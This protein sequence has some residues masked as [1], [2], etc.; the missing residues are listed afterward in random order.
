MKVLFYCGMP[1]SLAHGGAQIQ[2]EQTILALQKIGVDV[3]PAQWWE[4]LPKVDIYHHF[5]RPPAEVVRLAHAKGVRVVLQELLTEQGSRSRNR[6]RVQKWVRHAVQAT[7]PAMVSQVFGWESYR[8]AD[9]LIAN[10]TWEAHLM[11]YLFGAPADRVHVIANGIEE[12]FLNSAPCERGPWLICTATITHRKRVLEL[13]QAATL[14]RV[15]VWIIGKPYAENDS[16]GA[17]FLRLAKAKPEF[18]RYEGPISDR[19]RLAGIY[20]QA[21]G[22][23]LL[24]TMETLSLSSYEAVACGC[25]L[26]LSD[27]PWARSAFGTSVSYCS[28]KL[29]PEK[30]ASVLR[31]FYDQAPMLPVPPKPST[32]IEI[33]HQFKQV[34]QKAL[35]RRSSP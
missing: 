35:D 32:W 17:E 21:R 6:L 2:I 12:V 26:L 20:R 34:Y 27:L 29:S 9:A 11:S 33:A 22:F 18:V 31:A 15:P 24:S 16:Y 8:T 5:G 3:Q 14:A 7:M 1:F 30:T 28:V 10:T 19:A 25:P 23:V 13:A 4:D